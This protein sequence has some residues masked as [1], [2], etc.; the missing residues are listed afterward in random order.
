MV[1]LPRDQRL[2][3]VTGTG[4][5]PGSVRLIANSLERTVY[6]RRELGGEWVWE[7]I[8]PDPSDKVWVVV[9]PDKS[10]ASV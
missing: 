6:T 3:L 4:N 9:Q 2:F 8:C 5:I 10:Q 1:H 7:I